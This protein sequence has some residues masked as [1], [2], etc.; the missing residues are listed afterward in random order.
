MWL[1]LD[2]SYTFRYRVHL[3]GQGDNQV[4]LWKPTAHHRQD[5]RA[6]TRLLMERLGEYMDLT[7]LPLKP[8]ESWFSRHLLQYNKESYYKG[9][10]S[11]M[12]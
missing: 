4:I 2:F 6:E 9:L 3:I 1:L 11:R 8:E 10:F 5:L 7:Q 12:G